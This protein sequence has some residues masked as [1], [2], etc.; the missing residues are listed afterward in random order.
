MDAEPGLFGV[1]IVLT[2][3]LL[4]EDGNGA[5]EPGVGDGLAPGAPCLAF[6]AASRSRFAL[7]FSS[8]E[9][10]D[11]A[12]GAGGGAETEDWVGLESEVEGRKEDELGEPC[13]ERTD[14]T[15]NPRLDG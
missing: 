8:A 5:G 3:G 7:S 4:A 15:G 12:A 13:E 14:P 6:H 9:S 11:A 2:G 1:M 10:P